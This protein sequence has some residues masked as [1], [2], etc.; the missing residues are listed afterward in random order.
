MAYLKK[1]AFLENTLSCYL[2][3]V[4]LKT[5]LIRLLPTVL[6]VNDCRSQLE[7]IAVNLDFFET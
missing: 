3:A 1:H 7:M 5:Q 2:V 4:E 6:A